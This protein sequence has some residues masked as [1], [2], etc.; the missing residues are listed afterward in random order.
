M[1]KAIFKSFEHQWDEQVL[2][3]WTRHR[4]RAI[5][6]QR[7]LCYGYNSHAI[8]EVAFAPRETN[9]SSIENTP[10]LKISNYPT[11]PKRQSKRKWSSSKDDN[12]SLYSE[13]LTETFPSQDEA[14]SDD[15]EATRS[16]VKE[17]ETLK[18]SKINAETNEKH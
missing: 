10:P 5:T 9:Q 8:P 4:D 11:K 15:G 18:S 16:N 3:Y 7:F 1:D 13:T 2:L 6:K 14:P 17:Q 12:K